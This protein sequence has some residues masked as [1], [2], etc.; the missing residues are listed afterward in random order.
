MTGRIGLVLL[1]LF[2]VSLNASAQ[3]LLRWGAKSGFQAGLGKPVHLLVE[4]LSRPGI[5]GG[6]FCYAFSIVVWIYVLSRTDVSYAY[7]FLGLGFVFV[8]GASYLLLGE[9]LSLHRLAGTA[10]VAVGVAIIARS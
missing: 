6:F 3:V 4:L 8:A 10:L 5:V 1:I 2:S 7:P 9:P